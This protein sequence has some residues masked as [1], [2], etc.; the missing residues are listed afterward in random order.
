[1]ALFNLFKKEQPG[2]ALPPG[3]E[4]SGELLPH[5]PAIEK[6]ALPLIRIQATPNDELSATTSKFGGSMYTPRGTTWPVNSR[7]EALLPLAQVNFS[8]MP[9]LAGYPQKGIL[10]FYTGSDDVYGLDF[11]NPLNQDSF[12]VIYYEDV[13]TEDMLTDFSFLD[14][15]TFESGPVFQQMELTYKKAVDYAGANDI[16][17][18]QQFG[19]NAYQWTEQFGKKKEKVMDELEDLSSNFEHKIGGYASFTQEDPRYKAHENWVLLFQMNSQDDGIMW[20]DYGVSNFFIHPDDL[21]A[22]NFSRVL[23]HW[24]C[25]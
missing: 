8:E 23:Y 5:W 9:P 12:R 3:I 16:R 14:D 10:Q 21:K 20:G 13:D 15:S 2:I 22:K 17:F 24:D 4:L 1:M 7:G 6:T 25:T 19:M 18:E 11:D